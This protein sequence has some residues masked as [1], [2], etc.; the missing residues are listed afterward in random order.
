MSAFYSLGRLFIILGKEKSFYILQY[1]GTNTLG[2][3]ILDGR[4][5]MG[6]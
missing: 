6:P 5:H 4:N 3:D 1:Y 2:K